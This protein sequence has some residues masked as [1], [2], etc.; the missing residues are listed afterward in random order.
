MNQI[1][2]M[3]EVA[4]MTRKPSGT[5]R[6]WRHQ[7]IGPKSFKLGRSVVYREE[8]V[9]AWL[10]AQYAAENGSDPQGPQDLT[11]RE[12][13]PR[14]GHESRVDPLSSQLVPNAGSGD[15]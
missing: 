15:G 13:L 11:R 12:A 4:A 2:T 9:L 3:S 8:D 14:S 10:E 5:L 1:L 6:Y 7:G